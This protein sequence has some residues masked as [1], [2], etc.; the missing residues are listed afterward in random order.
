MTIKDIW[1]PLDFFL[2]SSFLQM[3][4]LRFVKCTKFFINMF[5]LFIFVHQVQLRCAA[6]KCVLWCSWNT[7]R[8]AA[9]GAV[10]LLEDKVHSGL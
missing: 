9:G 1:L 2:R 4:V 7:V 8:G 5:Y 10:S 3:K 6:H